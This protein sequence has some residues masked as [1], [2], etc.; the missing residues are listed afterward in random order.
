MLKTTSVLSTVTPGKFPTL[1]VA[2]EIALR[3]EVFPT[4]GCPASATTIGFMD[5]K[6]LYLF[7]SKM[8]IIII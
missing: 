4:L 2:L 7:R 1:S 8:K 5:Y 3:S 6:S